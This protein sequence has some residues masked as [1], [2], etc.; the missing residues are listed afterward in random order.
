MFASLKADNL[1]FATIFIN[2]SIHENMEIF[3]FWIWFRFPTT[4][5]KTNIHVKVYIILFQYADIL[6]FH[7]TV[8]QIISKLRMRTSTNVL[9]HVNYNLVQ[10]LGFTWLQLP[11]GTQSPTQPL[12]TCHC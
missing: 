12:S 1:H 3:L 11:R 7:S 5:L 4:L 2:D 9:T 6:S 8:I 10:Q